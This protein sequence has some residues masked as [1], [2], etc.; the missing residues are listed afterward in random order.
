VTDIVGAMTE[1]IER[2]KA[3]VLA[4]LDRASALSKRVESAS[5]FQLSAR[6]ARRAFR[7]E[8]STL[9]DDLAKLDRRSLGDDDL[10]AES[11]RALT[12]A[13]LAI[14]AG[15]RSTISRHVDEAERSINEASL[16]RLAWATKWVSI[17]V[18]FVA[19][20]TLVATL[21]VWK[22]EDPVRTAYDAQ[23]RCGRNA[24]EWFKRLYIDN[25]QR[26]FPNN[27]YQNHYNGK[28]NLC[29]ALVASSVDETKPNS[30]PFAERTTLLD[31]NENHELG[32][33]IWSIDPP[34]PPT[35]FRCEISG[36]SC[37]TAEEWN[38]LKKRYMEQ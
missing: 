2:A 11:S 26:E 9:R 21:P 29:L 3:E 5:D 1:R 6:S 34:Q 15:I 32:R 37:R 19:A 20:A 22:P 7:S 23:E 14:R 30:F 24:A 16:R 10:Y 4:L 17:A 28:L 13:D 35:I 38:A 8:I 18:L 33:F 25:A 31:V 27:F 12:A 36:T